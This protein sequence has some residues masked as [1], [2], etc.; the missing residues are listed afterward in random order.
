MCERFQLEIQGQNSKKVNRAL[1][2]ERFEEIKASLRKATLFQFSDS[3][4][5]FSWSRK[6]GAPVVKWI[7][8]ENEGKAGL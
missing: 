4:K 5:A 3:E 8:S 7:F 1:L 2:R 6:I